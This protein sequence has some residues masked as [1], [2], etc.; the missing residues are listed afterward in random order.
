M[1]LTIA[2]D[3]DGVLAEYDVW[4]GP[5]HIGEPIAGAREFMHGL[6]VL[7]Q[8]EV[9]VHTTREDK[10]FVDAWLDKHGFGELGIKVHRGGGKPI[11]VAYV[12]DRAVSC[13]PQGALSP[14]MAY[15]RATLECLMHVQEANK[16]YEEKESETKH[17]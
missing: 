9:V 2:V 5:E 7:T 12:D 15:S 6:Q 3:L 17:D 11:A 13:C 16:R 8:S 10:D 4:R 14:K 1:K